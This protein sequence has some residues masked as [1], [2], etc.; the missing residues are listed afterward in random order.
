MSGG[1]VWTAWNS[2]PRLLDLCEASAPVLPERAERDLELSQW[3]PSR[4]AV[5]RRWLRLATTHPSYLSEHPDEFPGVG[6]ETL[7]MLEQLGTA[8]LNL[9]LI[10]RLD[11]HQPGLP[12]NKRNEEM[13]RLTAPLRNTLVQMFGLTNIALLGKG[14]TSE[15]EGAEGRKSSKHVARIFE[16]LAL[17]T[18]GI[19]SLYRAHDTIGKFVDDGYAQAYRES[20]SERFTDY[21]TILFNE[22]KKIGGA[23]EVTGSGPDHDTV[24]TAVARLP[25]GVSASASAP[26]KKQARR[27]A[28]R[29]F[30]E[31]YR[32]DLLHGE[33]MA[34][35]P[36]QRVNIKATPLETRQFAAR[37]A[38]EFSAAGNQD[39]FVRALIHSS[40]VFEKFQKNETSTLSNAV[41]AHLGSFVITDLVARIQATTWLRL[42][43]DPDPE[44]ATIH[45]V[46]A[47]DLAPLSEELDIASHLLMGIGQKALGVSTE[48]AS[49]A[50]QAI[51]AA[52]YLS[53][54]TSSQLEAS[55]P[56]RLHTVL[57]AITG[58]TR[59]D[60]FTRLQQHLVTQG[61]AYSADYNA[62]GK[63]HNKQYQITATIESPVLNEK[64]SSRAQASSK[65]LAQ[66]AAAE[67]LVELMSAIAGPWH[68][69]VPIPPAERRPQS[70]ISSFLLRHQL[71][72]LPPTDHARLLWVRCGYLGGRL[73][74]NNDF[75]GFQGWARQV[76]KIVPAPAENGQVFRHLAAYYAFGRSQQ[77]ERSSLAQELERVLEWVRTIHSQGAQPHLMSQPG[78]RSLQATCK[79]QRLKLDARDARPLNEVLDNWEMLDGARL[80]KPVAR[81]GLDGSVVSGQT[82]I[83]LTACLTDL[84]ID[85]SAASVHVRRP[86]E[87]RA[88]VVITGDEQWHSSAMSSPTL[89]IVA[90]EVAELSYQQDDAALRID[91]GLVASSGE[92]WL[93]RAW[94]HPPPSDT[95]A[96]IA[97]ILHDLKNEL[98]ASQVA[99]EQDHVDRTSRLQ[100]ELQASRHLDNALALAER[101]AGASLLY[102]PARIGP[103]SVTSLIRHY[104]YEKNLAG[105]TNIRLMPPSPGDTM[106]LADPTLVRAVF[107][108]LVKN[109]I[110]AMPGG[111]EIRFDWADDPRDGVAMIEISDN[112]PGLPSH[113]VATVERGD[114]IISTK[115][116]GSGLG[117]ASARR[118]MRRM[119][120]AIHASS[121]G[122]G[123]TWLLTLPLANN[124]EEEFV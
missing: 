33:G 35:P 88:T 109:A 75:S 2:P 104:L 91:I 86:G 54:R 7:S 44:R 43:T 34:E 96:E 17:Q 52:A 79:V 67:P 57:Q 94:R 63:D 77:P 124:E 73:A 98:V 114:S 14:V 111:G 90:E 46:P 39:L 97:R 58:K 82:E 18:L 80:A 87:Q 25:N 69:A 120:G 81:D 37:L 4:T 74:V 21:Y 15:I 121:G 119:G 31:R 60:Y 106:V 56:A 110:E 68:G 116:Q 10:T 24:Y 41:L 108:N 28:A 113:L 26:N 50:V 13:G 102:V 38:E 5:A 3:A 92:N 89:R 23:F 30:I 72:A 6:L 64:I 53:H 112:G 123:Q 29:D 27:L 62:S 118:M 9:A 45:T 51:L 59:L 99:I 66:Q 12:V 103:T 22:F 47:G 70:I 8:A 71:A 100:K 107:D 84:A 95:D 76:V 42:T 36:V 122:Q 101:L 105:P 85:S 1:E 93:E 16:K 32:L 78:W 40:W 55:L 48:M 117:L 19:L 65:R 83:G 20:R 11:Q 115:H 61:L 49:D